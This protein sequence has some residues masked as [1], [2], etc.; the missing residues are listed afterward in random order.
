MKT[1][2][3]SEYLN[4]FQIKSS[5][6]RIAIMDYLMT[7]HTHPTVD[8]IYNSLSDTIP[9]LSKTTIYNTLKLFYDCGAVLM[10]GI[11]EKNLRFDGNIEPHAHFRCKSCNRIF[12]IMNIKY[13]VDISSDF[14]ICETQIYYVGYC[15]ECKKKH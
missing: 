7:H 13:N 9:T 2:Q 4:K 6:Q 15:N 10:L 5:I 1:K 12:D 11:D 14:E 8:E 3:I